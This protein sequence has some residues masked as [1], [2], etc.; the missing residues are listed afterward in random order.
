MSPLSIVAWTR[1]DVFGYAGCQS[2][3][4]WYPYNA[5]DDPQFDFENIHIH[6][7]RENRTVQVSDAMNYGLF[8]E[9]ESRIRSF[10]KGD[11]FH[12]SENIHGC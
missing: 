7:Y 5:T 4:F 2:S 10:V 9:S 11:I 3:S 1:P 8:D 6:Q 12:F